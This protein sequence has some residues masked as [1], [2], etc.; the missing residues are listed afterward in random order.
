GAVAR[1]EPGFEAAMDA[2]RRAH[3]EQSFRV[4]VQ[5]MSGSL[6]TAE[7]GRAFADLADASIETL[8]PAALAE[9]ERLGGAFPGAVAVVA[10]GKCGSREMT[11]GSDLDLMTLYRANDAQAV[12]KIK[13]WAAETTYGRFTQRLIAALSA[14]TGEGGLYE[15]DMRLRPSGSKGPVAVSFAAFQAYYDGDAEAWEFLALTRARVVWA[16]DAAF[17]AAA[18]GAIET[19][20]RRPRDAA[21]LARDV[22]DMRDLM[23]RER[24]PA[25]FWDV[26][27]EPG[28]LVDIEFAAQYLQLT[29]A[30]TGGP[31]HAHT[32]RALAAMAEA[33]LAAP[34]PLDD[35]IEAWRLQQDL[36]QLMKLAVSGAA[37]PDSEP[38]GFQ[39]TLA[40]AGHA[41]SF[42]ALRAKLVRARAAATRA[43]DN[44]VPAAP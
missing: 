2:V 40:R 10:L 35:L 6:S 4:G 23:T 33:G 43:Y 14:P 34:A 32:A 37:D 44:L 30:A 19:A 27:L 28:G 29:H 38:K 16:S 26:K 18:T 5:V 21:V 39:A 24:P 1:A 15:V 9:V 3:R 7:A 25:G 13:G 41:R 36:S 17:G 8:A 12:S 22:R 31:L 20:L 42:A 11:A